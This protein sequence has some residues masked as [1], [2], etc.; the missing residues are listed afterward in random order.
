VVLHVIHIWMQVYDNK[1]P[2]DIHQAASPPPSSVPCI[3]SIPYFLTIIQWYEV[4]GAKPNSGQT[5]Q[6]YQTSLLLNRPGMSHITH[7]THTVIVYVISDFNIGINWHEPTIIFFCL[8]SKM[9]QIRNCMILS[10]NLFFSSHLW[11][12]INSYGVIGDPDVIKRQ[13]KRS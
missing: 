11:K 10:W 2:E 9:L 7:Y 8:Y 13:I 1:E 5:S 6:I 12:Y 3:S 4:S